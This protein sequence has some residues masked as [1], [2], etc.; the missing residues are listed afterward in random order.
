MPSAKFQMDPDLQGKDF[1]Y[2]SPTFLKSI[3]EQKL[4]NFN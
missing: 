4:L 3:F 2:F 1:S